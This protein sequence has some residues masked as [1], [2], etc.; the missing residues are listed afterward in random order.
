MCGNPDLSRKA[1]LTRNGDPATPVVESCQPWL[2]TLWAACDTADCRGKS[3]RA[4]P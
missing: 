3:E 4:R 1:Q 2:A